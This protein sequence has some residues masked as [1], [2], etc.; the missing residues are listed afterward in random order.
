MRFDDEHQERERVRGVLAAARDA[1]PRSLGWDDV[2]ARAD[3]R[4]GSPGRWL[5]AA[6]AAIVVVVGVVGL[7]LL[8]GGRDPEVV[9]ADEDATTETVA[10]VDPLADLGDDDWVVPVGELPPGLQVMVA[11]LGDRLNEG[12]TVVVGGELV[13]EVYVSVLSG[14]NNR[15]EMEESVD[16]AGAIWSVRATRDDA[17]E[18]LGYTLHRP[19]G[20]HSVLVTTGGD[21]DLATAVAGSLGAV[22]TAELPVAV[23]DRDGDY[24]E[25]A[26]VEGARL[27][28]RGVNGFYCWR[29][30]TADS[31]ASGGCTTFVEPAS[32]IAAFGG[33][34]GQDD[35]FAAGLAAPNVVR[36]TVDGPDGP[37]LVVEP[38]RAAGEYEERF[39][40]TGDGG[41][42]FADE[43]DVTLDDGTVQT[44]RRELG[45]RWVVVAEAAGAPTA[46]TPP[47]ESSS[48]TSTTAPLADLLLAY[49]VGW[50]LP[51]GD[52]PDGY[53]VLVA[54]ESGGGSTRG[55]VLGGD[56]VPELYVG[57]VTGVPA[58]SAQGAAEI[59]GAGW[60]G[61]DMT[62][63]AGE[64]VGH[65]VRRQIGEVS[66]SVSGLTSP[67]VVERVAALLAPIDAADLPVPV[68]DSSAETTRVL[69][70]DDVG[71]EVNEA[72]GFYCMHATVGD[73]S[74]LTGCNGYT[75]PGMPVTSLG[76]LSA[77]ATRTVAVG[78]AEPNVARV[79]FELPDGSSV[80]VS[81]VDESGVFDQR[82]WVTDE[83]GVA[84]SSA[85]EQA[86]IT[87]DDG[88]TATATRIIGSSWVLD[89]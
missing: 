68:L 23:L 50:V 12:W 11:L 77:G 80:S 51:I 36:I 72:N 25:V 53:E 26:R 2:T 31:G 17:G 65:L 47:T 76:V 59:D 82:F 34:S 63:E 58:G 56:T 32:P 45:G 14:R 66:I 57:I 8:R 27:E 73:V 16:I 9:P 33:L 84:A 75:E 88:T 85:A 83:P 86:I 79:E 54:Q 38:V 42:L 49:T 48:S 37:R 10:V 89:G 64:V 30:L 46:S 24:T 22:P 28:V 41:L 44:V 40:L 39:W 78:L 5:L 74:G 55:A 1:A 35:S 7:I 62:N 4:G 15:P 61:S 20:D 70:I 19:V 52:L 21:F 6:A 60:I 87:Y 71:L 3:G 13:D 81:P 18:P 69:S 43:L 67:D 29:V